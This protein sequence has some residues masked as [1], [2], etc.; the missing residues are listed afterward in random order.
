MYAFGSVFTCAQ[1]C[2]CLDISVPQSVVVYSILSQ[3]LINY[4]TYTP[5][6][7]PVPF[8]IHNTQKYLLSKVC[9]QHH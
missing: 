5:G 6:A 3:G 1:I 2:V 8:A 7:C 9:V 4:Y